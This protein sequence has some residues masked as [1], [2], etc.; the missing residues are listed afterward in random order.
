[1]STPHLDRPTLEAARRDLRAAGLLPDERHHVPGPDGHDVP[2][3]STG[4][5]QR[6]DEANGHLYE[7]GWHVVS[8]KGGDEEG[9]VT[10]HR[11][12]L[13]PEEYVNHDVLRG[14]VERELGFSY[15]Q[16]RS[17]YR[18]GPLTATQR[19]LRGRID[20]RVLALS[21]AGTNL[22]ELGR[23]LGFPVKDNGN[24]RALENA[25]ARARKEQKP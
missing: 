6:H 5:V 14:L 13:H 7:G 2:A 12:V 25:L 17:V 15:E 3:N 20:A 23:A 4:R 9:G 24:C 1:M 11:G 19:E 22:A 10:S 18:Q 16:I 21:R 8:I